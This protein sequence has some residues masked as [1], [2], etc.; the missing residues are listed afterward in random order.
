MCAKRGG[1]PRVQSG[2]PCSVAHP[3]RIH[4]LRLNVEIVARNSNSNTPAQLHNMMSMFKSVGRCVFVCCGGCGGTSFSAMVPKSLKEDGL[5]S[6]ETNLK[7]HLG[8][9]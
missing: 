8:G 5:H 9:V 3:P 1:Q 2:T 6:E 7:H 4:S